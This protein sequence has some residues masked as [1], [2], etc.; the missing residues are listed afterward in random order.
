MIKKIISG[1]VFSTKLQEG[2]QKVFISC[3]TNTIGKNNPNMN[4]VA[5]QI[6]RDYS[7]DFSNL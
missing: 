1:S 3:G 5:G 2:E 7:P 4:S 6:A